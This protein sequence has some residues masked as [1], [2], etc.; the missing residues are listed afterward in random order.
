ME[1][2]NIHIMELMKCGDTIEY[3]IKSSIGLGLQPSRQR[4]SV[5]EMR[6]FDD[7]DDAQAFKDPR[8]VS[9]CVVMMVEF[10]AVAAKE[11]AKRQGSVEAAAMEW[12]PLHWLLPPLN[13]LLAVGFRLKRELHTEYA[14]RAFT[15]K[16]R[17]DKTNPMEGGPRPYQW[18]PKFL[19]VAVFWAAFPHTNSD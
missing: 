7:E 6:R 17:F 15:N 12:L 4:G 18:S 10:F 2:N 1:D 19:M 14:P 5:M 16:V 13:R 3:K 9:S 8:P 11:A